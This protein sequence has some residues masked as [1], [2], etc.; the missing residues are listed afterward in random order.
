MKWKN[1]Y[2]KFKWLLLVLHFNKSFKI[3]NF[4]STW[5]PKVNKNTNGQVCYS[6]NDCQQSL[7][8]ICT[9]FVCSCKT[10]QYFS[11]GGIC[12]NLKKNKIRFFHRS[13]WKLFIQTKWTEAPEM[14]FVQ[15]LHNVAL[16]TFVSIMC[17]L[18]ILI[19]VLP[20]FTILLL[21]LVVR[22]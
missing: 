1:R 7:G 22:N 16:I 17:V 10:S 19:R 18:A 21:R 2:F 15:A 6:N 13:F 14:I 4:N 3:V 11:S 20:D 12:S 8:L 9:A 5:I